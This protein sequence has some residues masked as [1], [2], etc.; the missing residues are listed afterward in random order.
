MQQSNLVNNSVLA[1]FQIKG[2]KWEFSIKSAGEYE[3]DYE[4][5]RVP[6]LFQRSRP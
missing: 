3:V 1:Q 5:F 2:E 4:F 6:L